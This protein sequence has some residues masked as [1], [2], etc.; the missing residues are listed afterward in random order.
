MTAIIRLIPTKTQLS[1]W[2]TRFKKE[3][4][5]PRMSV[6]CPIACTFSQFNAVLE[7]KQVWQLGPTWLLCKFSQCGSTRITWSHSGGTIASGLFIMPLARCWLRPL[8]VLKGRTLRISR[9][10][11]QSSWSSTAI[12]LKGSHISSVGAT[13]IVGLKRFQ[14][15]IIGSQSLLWTKSTVIRTLRSQ[16]L[17]TFSCVTS[18]PGP[19]TTKDSLF[20]DLSPRV[21][22]VYTL[23]KWS[24]RM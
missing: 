7:Y 20:T 12:V 21:L 18:R 16:R 8:R 4:V 11:T 23:D 17:E 22:Q 3:W 1:V 5:D 6:A 2:G 15:I 9:W 13:P 14:L 24:C 10:A 19:L